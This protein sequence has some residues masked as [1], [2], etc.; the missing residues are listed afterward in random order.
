MSKDEKDTVW[1][2]FIIGGSY[3]KV[4]DAM[5]YIYIIYGKGLNFDGIYDYVCKKCRKIV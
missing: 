2:D 1:C 5:W 4:Y 3:G